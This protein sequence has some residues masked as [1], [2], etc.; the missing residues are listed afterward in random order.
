[1]SMKLKVEVERHIN[2]V[3]SDIIGYYILVIFIYYFTIHFTSCIYIYFFF[4][5]ERFKTG[6]VY[7]GLQCVCVRACVGVWVCV[8]VA[9]VGMGVCVCV[10]YIIALSLSLSLSLSLCREK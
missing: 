6:K 2:F 10:S 4:Q 3:N 1:M 5:L 9:C 8:G 7:F